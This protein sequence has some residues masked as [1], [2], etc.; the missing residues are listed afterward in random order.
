ML[1]PSKTYKAFLDELELWAPPAFDVA[2]RIDSD[3]D[4]TVTL[5]LPAFASKDE[6]SDRKPIGL[7]AGYVLRRYLIAL[8][9]L[10][11]LV[12]V[13]SAEWP[14]LRN[15]FQQ[16]LARF[17]PG[18]FFEG[19]GQASERLVTVLAGRMHLE[20]PTSPGD[21]PNLD[22]MADLLCDFRRYVDFQRGSEAIS[23]G[24]AIMG[25]ISG[26][27]WVSAIEGLIELLDRDEREDL[28]ERM[29]R[30][31]SGQYILNSRSVNSERI[32][33]FHEALLSATVIPGEE[34]YKIDVDGLVGQISGS[35]VTDN[36]RANV[37][38]VLKSLEKLLSDIPFEDL[39]DVLGDWGGM[40][41]FS[42]VNIIPTTQ[43]K[44]ACCHLLLA[45]AS[46]SG[47]SRRGLVGVLRQVRRHLIECF[48][49]TRVVILLTDTWDPSKFRESRAD[50]EA[51]RRGGV[52]FVTGVVSGRQISATPLP[53]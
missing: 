6:Q 29:R 36:D 14:H 27:A 1:A 52:V 3:I 38:Q 2:G 20:R 11:N 39:P 25:E 37:A 43:S 40:H 4:P 41:S 16:D 28:A 17:A 5:D 24:P 10:E 35:D 51:H 50:I 22:E 23:A 34:M 21:R 26:P 13:L 46:G 42:D 32:R 49:I 44:G 19:S 33:R 30:Y 47:A 15:E 45:T 12:D 7:S 31:L 48:G 8:G 53:F 9:Q 18:P